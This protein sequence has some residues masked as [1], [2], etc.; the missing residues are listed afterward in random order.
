MI[1]FDLD[2]TLWDSRAQVADSWNRL[3]SEQT[4][5]DIEVTADDIGRNMGKTM[6]QI[7]D[8]V[9]EVLP[10]EERYIL[11][12]RCEEFENE[13]ISEHGGRLFDGVR[14]TLRRLAD[15]GI[16][17][18][19]VSNCQEGYIKAFIDSMDMAE[20]FI[21]YEEWGHT[22]K[23]KADNIRLVMER[24][25]TDKA[26]YVGDIQKDSDA[27]HEVGIPCINAAYGFGEIKD[28][29]AKVDN[30]REIPEALEDIGYLDKDLIEL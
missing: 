7:A 2:G 3:I 1:I 20:F 16:A 12:R 22:G 23:L 9:F 11:A 30:F 21:D 14:E 10:E 4:D 6:N 27:A 26:V 28:A 13:Y 25:G 15:L 17:M 19:V 8:D 5:Y 29:E 18:S 24:N